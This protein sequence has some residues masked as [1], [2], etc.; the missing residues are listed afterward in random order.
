MRITSNKQILH[1]LHH[2]ARDAWLRCL[3]ISS[4]TPSASR[5]PAAKYEITHSTF[6]QCWLCLH[7]AKMVP[8]VFV[9]FVEDFWWPARAFLSSTTPFFQQPLYFIVIVVISHC[10]QTNIAQ[11]VFRDLFMYIGTSKKLLA[12]HQACQWRSMVLFNAGRIA[13]IKSLRLAIALLNTLENVEVV[14]E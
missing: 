7:C 6:T 12:L 13:C 14:K 1:L 3:S 5:H 4:P 9:I 8:Q 2:V 10:L 11:N